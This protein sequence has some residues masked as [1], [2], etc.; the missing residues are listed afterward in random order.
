M[1]WFQNL[2]LRVT[3]G[4]RG[5]PY[6]PSP[7][8]KAGRRLS[9]LG[10]RLGS[11]RRPPAPLVSSSPRGQ[12][13]RGPSRP[14]GELGGADDTRG[15]TTH[16]HGEGLFGPGR[17]RPARK[18][19]PHLRLPVAR[20]GDALEIHEMRTKFRSGRRHREKVVSD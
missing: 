15:S 2:V 5:E 18:L 17:E 1:S 9:S 3:R 13:G 8:R 12:G 4:N 14:E 11:G 19:D 6:L 16:R 10:L 20:L 7:Q